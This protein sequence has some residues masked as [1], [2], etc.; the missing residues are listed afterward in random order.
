MTWHNVNEHFLS[1]LYWF[2]FGC[3]HLCI[4]YHFI[5]FAQCLPIA[6]EREKNYWL[7]FNCCCNF[8][9]KT[10]KYENKQTN[11]K[12]LASVSVS[13]S[14]CPS[15]S[16]AHSALSYTYSTIMLLK[17][18]LN[19]WSKSKRL[20]Q[21]THITLKTTK[22][23]TNKKNEWMFV[24]YKLYDYVSYACWLAGWFPCDMWTL[25]TLRT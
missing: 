22:Q 17:T 16:T 13:V 20:L 14:V 15:T 12:H 3:F 5:T 1:C 23:E 8:K 19:S 2:L 11:T 24:Y 7:Q 10:T 6:D 21:S 4:S 25:L 9:L 18:T